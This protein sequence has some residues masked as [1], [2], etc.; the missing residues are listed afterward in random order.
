MRK[1]QSLNDAY[2]EMQANQVVPQ[3][4]MSLSHLSFLPFYDGVCPFCYF[5]PNLHLFFH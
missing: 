1:F 2:Q 4:A 3:P 5:F